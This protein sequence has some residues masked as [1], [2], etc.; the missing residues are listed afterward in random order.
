MPKD[1]A[2]IPADLRARK[3]LSIADIERIVY[4]RS[5]HKTLLGQLD[6]AESRVKQIKADIE[7]ASKEEADLLAAD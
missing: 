3:D 2:T 7:S 1:L 5:R 4:L 6:S